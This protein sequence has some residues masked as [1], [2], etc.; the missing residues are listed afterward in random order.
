MVVQHLPDV[1]ELLG[2]L[3]RQFA[4]RVRL[5]SHLPGQLMA[6]FEAAVVSAHDC[7][8]AVA[9][10]HLVLASRHQIAQLHDDLLLLNLHTNQGR[11]KSSH[12]D[13][14]SGKL[15]FSKTQEA[16]SRFLA[17]A[18]MSLPEIA[19]PA[20]LPKLRIHCLDRI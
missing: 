1:F 14:G 4:A 11:R 5:L 18:A 6:G 17:A 13:V 3:A 20:H 12:L 8:M 9:Q 10:L 16:I 19:L 2:V 15:S 7:P